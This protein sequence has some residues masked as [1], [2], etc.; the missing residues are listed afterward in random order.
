[1]YSSIFQSSKSPHPHLFALGSTTSG[2]SDQCRASPSSA[3]LGPT[4][5]V[6]TGHRKRSVRGTRGKRVHRKAFRC[7][8]FRLNPIERSN[9]PYIYYI[10]PV[11][12]MPVT[13]NLRGHQE[14]SLKPLLDC[15][16]LQGQF[17][18]PSTPLQHHPTRHGHPSRGN[19]E[20]RTSQDV[21]ILPSKRSETAPGPGFWDPQSLALCRYVKSSEKDRTACFEGKG[22]NWMHPFP[23]FLPSF[24]A[25]TKKRN[26]SSY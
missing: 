11:L 6:A 19:Q 10:G 12:L 25:R 18:S 26:L 1:M 15:K 13:G 17:L 20:T 21:F 3:V 8:Q 24:R 7:T 16:K 2:S 5:P 9:L 4:G 14:T 22:L 23:S